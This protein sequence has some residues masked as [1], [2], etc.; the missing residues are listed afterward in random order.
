MEKY[1]EAKTNISYLQKQGCLLL[2]KVDATQMESHPKLKEGEFDR[3]V[4]GYPHTWEQPHDL[5]D[6]DYIKFVKTRLFARS[7]HTNEFLYMKHTTESVSEITKKFLEKSRF[8]QNY[9]A[10]ETMK[11]YRCGQMLKAEI[12]EFILMADYQNF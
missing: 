5:H 2:D 11:M 6:G 7:K 3:I 4:F 10:N 12:R 8:C 1:N 9:V